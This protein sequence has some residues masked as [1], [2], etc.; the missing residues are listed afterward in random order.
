MVQ[1]VN[2]ARLNKASTRPTSGGGVSSTQKMAAALVAVFCG[3]ALLKKFADKP[4]EA[5]DLSSFNIVTSYE[6]P[7]IQ[8]MDS[9]LRIEFCQA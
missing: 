4:K 7:A 8:K 1:A 9:T 3:P 6:T 5:V 2:Q